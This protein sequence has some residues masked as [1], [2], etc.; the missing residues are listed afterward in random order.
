MSV[1]CAINKVYGSEAI[2]GALSALQ[3]DRDWFLLSI[4]GNL[5]KLADWLLSANQTRWEWD[6][7]YSVAILSGVCLISLSVI[8]WRLRRLEVVA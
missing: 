8:A 5:R 7:W 2:G 4:P 6:P 1:E 3:R